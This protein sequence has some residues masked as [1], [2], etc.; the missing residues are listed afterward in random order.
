MKPFTSAMRS[1]TRQLISTAFVLPVAFT[2]ARADDRA[3]WPRWRGPHDN[4]SVENGSYPTKFEHVLWKAPLPGKGCS[5]PAVR[6]RRI[7]LTAPA[8]G[9]DAVLAFDWSGKPLWVTTLGPE[10]AGKHRNGSGSNASPA[11]DGK[12]V[13]V[14]FKSGT[15]AALEFDGRV[16]W[17]TN[18]VER[19]GPD[20]LYWDHGT[21]PVL[22]EKYVIMV[23]MHNG[24]SWLAAFDKAT[25]QMRGKVARNY[26]TPVEGD[27][28]YTTPVVISHQGKEALL[29]WGAQQVTAHDTADGKLLWSC[30]D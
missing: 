22:T 14:Y 21:S 2:F 23:R 5:T 25:G 18:L 17:Q 27:H 20:T 7:Y 26:E 6:D 24:E 11:T 4:G 3:D 1:R 19:F 10:R 13:F 28:A 15:L 29:V 12:A 16:R 8:D 9:Q 30:G